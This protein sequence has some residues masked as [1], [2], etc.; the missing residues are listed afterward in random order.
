MLCNVNSCQLSPQP[1]LYL[2]WSKNSF[3]VHA[4][5]HK[6][7]ERRF[8]VVGKRYRGVRRDAICTHKKNKG[9]NNEKSTSIISFLGTKAKRTRDEEWK[10]HSSSSGEKKS[11][12]QFW[13]G[14]SGGSSISS[15]GWGDEISRVRIE[16]GKWWERERESVRVG[17]GYGGGGC[18]CRSRR[19]SSSTSFVVVS[20]AAAIRELQ[21][22]WKMV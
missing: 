21:L 19:K 22:Y 4:L 14:S 16:V 7:S 12:R 1:A 5:Q 8:S 2:S 20:S 17:G 9:L 10:T 6:R 15:G 11:A 13:G 3:H 18:C